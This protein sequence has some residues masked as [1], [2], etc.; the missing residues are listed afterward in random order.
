MNAAVLGRITRERVV[1]ILR[2]TSSVDLDGWVAAAVGA[3]AGCLEITL[4]TPGALAAIGRARRDH[5][6]LL[7]GGGTVRSTDEVAAL[8]DVGAA[9]AISPHFDPGLVEACAA[10]RLASIPG[11]QTPTEMMAA[12]RAG[13]TALKLFPAPPASGVTALRA[14]LP[15]LPLVA[16]G[17]VSAENLAGYLA[18]GCVAVGVGGSIFAENLGTGEVGRRVAAVLQA[19]RSAVA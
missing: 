10:R 11:V 12:W 2:A 9:F 17:G 19:A 1:F 4:P 18:A 8:A 3:G 7:V 15:D 6:A 14:P 5:P 16:V 13:A